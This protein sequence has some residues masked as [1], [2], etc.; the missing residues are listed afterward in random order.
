M[1]TEKE[2]EDFIKE[3]DILIEKVINMKEYTATA[4]LSVKKSL[5]LRICYFLRKYKKL[6]EENEELKAKLEFKKYG[7]LDDIEFE[8]HIEKIKHE[9][10]EDEKEKWRKKIRDRVEELKDMQKENADEIKRNIR[11]YSMYVNYVVVIII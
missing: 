5:I 6:Q 2:I 1:S 10:L 7:D 9:S 4:I 3:I 8:E 11:F